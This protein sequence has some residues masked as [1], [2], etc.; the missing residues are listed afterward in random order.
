MGDDDTFQPKSILIHEVDFIS[1][2]QRWLGVIN[3]DI[4]YGNFFSGV[5]L[6]YEVTY[7]VD[8]AIKQKNINLK[9]KENLIPDAKTIYEIRKLFDGQCYLTVENGM[10]GAILD[11]ELFHYDSSKIDY[12]N[13]NLEVIPLPAL[14][15]MTP[16]GQLKDDS[17]LIQIHESIPCKYAWQ[18]LSYATLIQDGNMMHSFSD[19]SMPRVTQEQMQSTIDLTRYISRDVYFRMLKKMKTKFKHKWSILEN[20]YHSII[21]Y[22]KLGGDVESEFGNRTTAMGKVE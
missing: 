22:V 2:L 20:N 13:P 19:G 8:E 10:N 9:N 15:H 18:G 12:N 5:S 16:I 6:G 14:D 21:E 11:T 7:L 4:V 3:F 1:N 17:L